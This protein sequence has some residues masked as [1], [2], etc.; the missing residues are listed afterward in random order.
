MSASKGSPDMSQQVATE[1]GRSPGLPLSHPTPI[2]HRLRDFA[3]AQLLA[4]ENH[5]ECKGEQL[6]AGIH[7]C[8]KSLRRARAALALGEPGFAGQASS[9]DVD[10]G[11]LCR[12]LS[13]VRDAQALVDTLKRLQDTAPELRS[14]LP[15]AIAAA[16]LRRDHMARKLLLRDEE[17]RS[18]RRRIRA[19]RQRLTGL[20]WQ[21]VDE[22]TVHESLAHSERR[23]EKSE[24][25]A[26]RRKDDNDAWHR[27]RRRLRRL[28]QQHTLLRE[29]APALGLSAH[30]AEDKANCL[31]EA[32]D[33]TLLMA[34]CRSHSPFRPEHRRLLRDVARRRLKHARG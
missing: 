10:L 22:E 8:R 17:L 2:G 30:P 15:E 33:D 23:M 31:S 14:V 1:A 3:S 34:R 24:A 19:L 7:Q 21:S 18:R 16:Q 26:E 13:P 6:H 28:H 27:F 32:Q 25:R 12:G 29:L 20:D 5:L 11:R 4:A 9:L